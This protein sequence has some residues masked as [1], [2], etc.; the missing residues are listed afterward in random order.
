[1][2]DPRKGSLPL[3]S[4]LQSPP[5]AL[6]SAGT[7]PPV[8]PGRRVLLALVL[9]A[10]A[11]AIYG[12]TRSR[13]DLVDFEVYRTAAQRVV[14]AEPLY[15]PEDGHWQFKYLPVFALIV[16]PAG[17]GSPELVK[18]I[19][20]ALGCGL[21]AL[22]FAKTVD[23]LPNR[24]RAEGG[25]IALAAFVTAKLWIKELVEGQTNLWLAALALGAVGA[26]NHRRRTLAGVLVGAAVCVIGRSGSARARP[27]RPW[28]SSP[29]SSCSAW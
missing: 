13:R 8:P 18:A 23:L 16:A 27:H 15:R 1:M 12:V 22:L 10:L 17:R 19:W 11:A 25:L 21:V 7:I 14:A 6:V 24:R 29:D 3:P 28:R 9:V 5:S 20:F 4:A 2:A 26:A